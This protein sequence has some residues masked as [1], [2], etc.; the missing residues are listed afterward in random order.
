MG[1]KHGFPQWLVITSALFQTIVGRKEEGEFLA[2][3][4]KDYTAI[5]GDKT[6][7]FR[8]KSKG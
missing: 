6:P 4:R 2:I 1:D 7:K 8:I 5:Q 3:L